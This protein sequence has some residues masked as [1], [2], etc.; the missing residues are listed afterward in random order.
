MLL[1]GCAASAAGFPGASTGAWKSYVY[2]SYGTPVASPD[3]Y[4]PVKQYRGEGQWALTAPADLFAGPDGKLYVADTKNNRIVILDRDLNPLDTLKFVDNN[5]MNDPLLQPESVFVGKNG[6]MYISDTGK[7]RVLVVNGD[8]HVELQIKAPKINLNDQVV[9][10]KPN[11][12]AVDSAGRIYLLS[13]GNYMCFLRFNTDGT[14]DT[15][16]GSNRVDVTP[17]LLLERFWRRILTKQQQAAMVKFI[18]IEYSGLD[19]DA[20]DFIFTSVRYSASSTDELKKLNLLGNNVLQSSDYGDLDYVSLRSNRID[21]SFVDVDV[22]A[23]GFM[24]GLDATRGRIFQYDQE[25]DLLYA[26]GTLGDQPG[27]FKEPAAIDTIGDR[28][29][30]LDT[31]ENSITMFEMTPYGAALRD[32]LQKNED[33]LYTEAEAAWRKVLKYNGNLEY[34]Y[35]GLGKALLREG[36]YDQAAAYFKLGNDRKGY[37]NAYPELRSGKLQVAIPVFGVCVIA[38]FIGVKIRKAVK[39]RRK[40]ATAHA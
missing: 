28:I 9:E 33:G 29:Y 27:A 15:Y 36:K 40:E 21:T 6:L 34:A 18:P 7:K 1:L 5:Y 4:T 12:L 19:I 26:F 37:E 22:D 11:R 35:S 20:E 24:N 25:G 32:A 13:T 8:R 16:F 30:V 38:A 23:E 2:D 14:F 10:F 31:A 17:Q 3:G 39:R